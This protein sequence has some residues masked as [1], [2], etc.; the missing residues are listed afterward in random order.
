MFPAGGHLGLRADMSDIIF[1]WDH[2]TTIVTKFGSNWPVVSEKKIFE[3]FFSKIWRKKGNN[4]KMAFRIF[5][6]NSGQVDLAMLINFILCQIFDICDGFGVIS[7]KQQF[8]PMFY[9]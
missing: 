8:T 5:F 1:K 6:K 3:E 4:S 7:Q 2:P 9:L